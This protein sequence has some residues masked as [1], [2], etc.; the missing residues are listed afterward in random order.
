MLLLLKF[1]LNLYTKW[2][3]QVQS[4]STGTRPWINWTKC[5][6]ARCTNST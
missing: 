6:R 5:P 2:P 3:Q 1:S 4:F